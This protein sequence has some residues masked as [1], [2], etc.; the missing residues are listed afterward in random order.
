MTDC[1][2]CGDALVDPR[3]KN[4]AGWWRGPTRPAAVARYLHLISDRVSVQIG[5]V[6][7]DE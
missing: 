4:E 1:D 3:D 2:D 7:T 5:G 6:A